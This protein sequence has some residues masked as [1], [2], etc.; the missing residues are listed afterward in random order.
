MI[1]NS[2]RTAYFGIGIVLVLVLF[3]HNF[4]LSLNTFCTTLRPCI[5]HVVRTVHTCYNKLVHTIP[6]STLAQFSILDSVVCKC[7][8]SQ[9]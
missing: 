6:Y 8:V 2:L 9:F 1:S 5:V 4:T 3:F 7:C